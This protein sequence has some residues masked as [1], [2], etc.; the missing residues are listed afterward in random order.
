MT[1]KAEGVLLVLEASS[2]AIPDEVRQR[3]TASTDLAELSRWLRRATV[4]SA[5]SAI[6]DETS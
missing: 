6:F 3:I 1:G 4:T 2:L 5:A